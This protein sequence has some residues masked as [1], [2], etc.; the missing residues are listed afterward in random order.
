M[1]RRHDRINLGISSP[2]HIDWKIGR[3]PC[4]IPNANSPWA[5]KTRVIF[6]TSVTMPVTFDMAE[7][8]PI[9]LLSAQ[10]FKVF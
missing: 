1:R 5:F 4:I 2:G 7:K 8:A 6:L 9:T 3:T 10:D